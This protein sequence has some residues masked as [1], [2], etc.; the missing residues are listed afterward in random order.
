MREFKDGFEFPNNCE[1]GGGDS[2]IRKTKV[3]HSQTDGLDFH[4][5]ACFS[6]KVV[7]QVPGWSLGGDRRDGERNERDS[8]LSSPGGE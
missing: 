3:G 2:K 5:A 8:G 4:C 7:P 1:I 6:E